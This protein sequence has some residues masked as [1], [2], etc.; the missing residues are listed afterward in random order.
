MFLLLLLVSMCYGGR[1][2]SNEN[3][4][5]HMWKVD[6]KAESIPLEYSNCVVCVTIFR[7]RKS[8][9]NHFQANRELF[10]MNA[11]NSIFK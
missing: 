10:Q 1:N 2:L 4:Q 9:D 8:P 3:A 11:I 7:E 5:F 6:D